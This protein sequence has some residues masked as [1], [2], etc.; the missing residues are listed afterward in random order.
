LTQTFVESCGDFE[1]DH[2]IRI[3]G[4]EIATPEIATPEINIPTIT[5]QVWC[6]SQ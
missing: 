4:S 2:L 3:H 5:L 6:L 1:V